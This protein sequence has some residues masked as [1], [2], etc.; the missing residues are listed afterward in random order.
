MGS[1]ITVQNEA[2]EDLEH[3]TDAAD[4]TVTGL[5]VRVGG[6]RTSV[7]AQN[8]ALNVCCFILLLGLVGY[9]IAELVPGLR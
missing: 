2:L 9:T 3:R 5:T 7:S 4:T 1:E 6:H 8:F